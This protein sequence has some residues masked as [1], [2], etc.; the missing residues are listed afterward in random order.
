MDQYVKSCLI[1]Q[2]NKHSIQAKS[3]LLE[4]LPIPS[5]PYRDISMD[6]ITSLPKCGEANS[7]LVVVDRF[8]KTARFVSITMFPKDSKEAIETAPKLTTS[9]FFDNWISLYG[10]PTSILSD[11]DVKFIT[12]FWQHVMRKLGSK[13]ILT[14]ALHPQRDGQTGRLNGFSQCI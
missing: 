7:I 13:V 2:R 11:R 3:G 8:S 1:C 9:V 14:I 12:Q 4:P 10:V 5:L 6:F